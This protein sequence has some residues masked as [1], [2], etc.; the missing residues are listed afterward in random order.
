VQ[1]PARLTAPPL[2]L[3]PLRLHAVIR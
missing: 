2:A 3:Q 1:A